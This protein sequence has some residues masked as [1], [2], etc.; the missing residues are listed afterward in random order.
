MSNNRLRLVSCNLI[1]HVFGKRNVIS[2]VQGNNEMRG[3]RPQDNLS[4][5]GIELPVE[6]CIIN[7]SV[8]R[9]INL[10]RHCYDLLD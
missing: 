9:Y 10:P 8:T 7:I 1:K 3:C 4:G 2:A 6:F 5:L